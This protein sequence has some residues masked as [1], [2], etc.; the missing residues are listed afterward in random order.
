MNNNSFIVFSY[1]IGIILFLFVVIT[2]WP[3]EFL[4]KNIEKIQE[5]NLITANAEKSQKDIPRERKGPQT[6]SQRPHIDPSLPNLL[7]EDPFLTQTL[8]KMLGPEFKLRGAL[9][10]AAPSFGKPDN[11]HPFNGYASV[12]GWILQCT[13][14][15]AQLE[16]GKFATFA[17]NMAI[18]IEERKRKNSEYMEFWVHLRDKVYW[19]PL[20]PSHFS[21]DLNLASW[22]LQKHQVTAR[23]FK[24]YYDVVMNPHVQAT[25]ALAMRTILNNI[26]EVEVIDDL[27]LVVRVKT[28]AITLPD[29]TIEHRIKYTDKFSMG[30]MIPLASFVYKYFPDGK[31]IIEDDSDSKA[32]RTNAVW[33]QNF[34][35]HWASNV[36]P[37]CGPWLFDGIN[38]QQITFKRNPD[39]YFPYAALTEK[40]EISFKNTPEAAMVDFKANKSDLFT[41]YPPQNIEITSFLNSNEYKLQKTRN[42][43]LA[44]DTVEYNPYSYSY[45]GWNEASPFFKNKKVRQ[46]MTLAI[47]R[48]RIIK[49]ILNGKA[50]SI[51]GPAYPFFLSYDSSITPWPYDPQAARRLLEEAGWFDR[52][53]SGIV[54]N[55][56]DGK[57]VSFRFTLTYSIQSAFAAKPICEYIATALKDIGID[58]KISGVGSADWAGSFMTK[59]FDAIFGAWILGIGLLSLPEQFRAIWYSSGAKEKGSLNSIGF[60]NTE[61][62]AIIDKLDYEY[63]EQKRVDLYHRFHAIIHEEQPYTFLFT[64]TVTIAYRDYVQNIFIPSQRKDLIPGADVTAPDLSIIWLK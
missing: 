64:P 26:E 11:L 42:P 36:I 54:S 40:Q 14:S 12:G 30:S 35:K 59:K 23:D 49:S 8:P 55:I 58:C 19:E 25:R 21:Q 27:T 29:G 22:F 6:L 47:D 32:Y 3:L 60:M 28:A 51:T 7:H 9:R 50:I 45:V 43:N 46:A 52:D 18:K 4:N 57:T 41:I 16:F 10:M 15:I 20:N 61:A 33:A 37:S 62:D 2:Y 53:G 56:V 5:P 17:P 48:E 24:F 63:N 39:Y 38:D 31:K 1:F 13:V 44:V 34:A